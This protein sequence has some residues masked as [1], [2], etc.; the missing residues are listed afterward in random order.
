M[1][2]RTRAVVCWLELVTAVLILHTACHMVI[3]ST[4][5]LSRSVLKR[6]SEVTWVLTDPSGKCSL[7]SYSLQTPRD[8][9]MASSGRVAG[10]CNG[11]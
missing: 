3:R 10:S 4:H 5:S 1:L 6:T 2:V 7:V 11:C 8:E 9:V